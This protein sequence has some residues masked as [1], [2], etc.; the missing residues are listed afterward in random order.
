MATLLLIDLDNLLP[1]SS[2]QA[3]P[4]KKQ[5]ID[6]CLRKISGHPLRVADSKTV[7]VIAMN[8]ASI[9]TRKLSL[10]LLD[11]LMARI[12]ARCIQKVN[13]ISREIL[14]VLSMPEAAD[15]ALLRSLRMAAEPKGAVSV[16]EL[17]LVSN[18]AGIRA[19]FQCS[20][21]PQG[22]SFW[23]ARLPRPVPRSSV[24]TREAHGVLGEHPG[25][26]VIDSVS[27]AQAASSRTVQCTADSLLALANAI[28][29]EPA[30]LTQLGATALSHQGSARLR[31]LLSRGPA[32]L[33]C[34]EQ[35][36]IEFLG[37]PVPPFRLDQTTLELSAAGHGTVALVSPLSRAVVFS[38]IPW[39]LLTRTASHCV[40]S[41]QSSLMP[42][43]LL[44]DVGAQ[45]MTGLSRAH[46]FEFRQFSANLRCMLHE[47]PEQDATPPEA[48]WLHAKGHGGKL[49]ATIK[50]NDAFHA[51][52]LGQR[53]IRQVSGQ[54]YP[55]ITNGVS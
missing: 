6:L 54:F 24:G 44:L 9:T 31:S 19:S 2:E 46:T 37:A 36:R 17:V 1:Y 16:N 47:K 55:T 42:D 8:L 22:G 51:G 25:W 43:S 30:L 52:V 3:S 53:I 29:K 23:H 45:R 7:V 11:Q 10:E 32:R 39:Y 12:A 41:M 26:R 21:Q 50:L 18:D 15:L 49:A 48:W 35:E 28:Q 5:L 20:F 13:E 27:L 34:H 38:K 40:R 14:L 33:L 4:S